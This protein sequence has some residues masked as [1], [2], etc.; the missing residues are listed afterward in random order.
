M[1]CWHIHQL[2]LCF[3]QVF[4][5]YD[6]IALFQLLLLT[7]TIVGV[8]KAEN[9]STSFTKMTECGNFS[10]NVRQIKW[11]GLQRDWVEKVKGGRICSRAGRQRWEWLRWWSVKSSQEAT[12]RSKQGGVNTLQRAHNTSPWRGG[13]A[14]RGWESLRVNEGLKWTALDGAAERVCHNWISRLLPSSEVV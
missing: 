11:K 12:T 10:I 9:I 13:P 5:A 7:V 8:R 2:W 14:E 4:R 1:C 3:K 6:N